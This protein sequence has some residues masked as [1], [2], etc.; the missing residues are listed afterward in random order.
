MLITGA[1]AQQITTI[2]GNGYAGSDSV[3]VAA[4]NAQLNKPT[5]LAYDSHF[6]LFVA[7]S[8]DG[9]IRKI[10]TAGVITTVCSGGATGLGD[11]GSAYFANLSSPYAVACDQHNNLY[12]ADYGNSRVRVIKASGIIT[13][14]AGGGT[15]GD[16][17]HATAAQ[18]SGPTGLAIDPIGNLYIADGNNN[19][20][21]KVDTFGIITTIAGTM[22]SAGYSGDGG[23]AT[24]AM[25]YN[26]MGLCF[27]TL[28]NLYIADCY[29]DC[30]RIVDTSGNINTFAG[31]IG[32]TTFSGDGGAATAA[33]INLPTDVKS[34]IF[35]N[36]YI[37]DQGNNAIRKVNDSGIIRTAAGRGS[38]GFTGDGG[39]ATN[40]KL[41]KPF[42]LIV[43][44][45]GNLLITDEYNERVRKVTSDTVKF[46]N[47]RHQ[48]VAMC[49]RDSV[50]SISSA[51]GVT[52]SN[53][54]FAIS[55]SVAGAPRHGRIFSSYSA[56]VSG[57][58]IAP[59]D[60]TYRSDS[61]YFGADSFKVLASDGF[62]NDS[63]LIV[64][65]RVN[66]LTAPTI[67]T[68]GYVCIGDTLSLTASVIGGLWFA[69]NNRL[70]DTSSIFIGNITG[71]DTIKYT[72]SN[73][74]GPVTSQKPITVI[75]TPAPP[76]IL[77]DSFVCV[78]HSITLSSTVSGGTWTKSNANVS[79]SAGIIHGLSAGYDTVYYTISNVCGLSVAPTNI[80]IDSP[81]TPGHISGD[82]VVCAGIPMILTETSGVGYW[83][84]TNLRAYIDPYGNFTGITGGLDTVVYTVGN[85][86]G[87]WSAQHAVRV[88]FY[89]AGTIIAPGNICIGDSVSVLDT[90]SSR[91]GVWNITN[92][93][94]TL[95]GTKITAMALGADTIE[96]S[97]TNE[98][99]LFTSQHTFNI[100]PFP[101]PG[102]ISGGD[103]LCVAATAAFTGIPTGGSWNAT[104][105]SL[106]VD[107]AGIA[108]GVYG[109]WDTLLYVLN[110]G[111][112]YTPCTKKVFVKPF[113]YA[114]TITGPGIICTG[115]VITLTDTTGRGTWR[116]AN[117]VTAMTVSGN[118][119]TLSPLHTGSN[120]IFYTIYNNCGP[121]T[122]SR[123]ITVS[124]PPE[125]AVLL[126]PAHICVGDTATFTV[127][128]GSGEWSAGSNLTA[129]P[130]RDSL[131]FSVTSL[132][133]GVDT[134]FYLIENYCG[135]FRAM[136]AF[137][138]ITT[139]QDVTVVGDS[140]LCVESHETLFGSP[141]GGTWSHTGGDI[142]VHGG[143]ITAFGTGTSTIFYSISNMCGT[144]IDTFNLHVVDTG[145]GCFPL[146]I[147]GQTN[148]AKDQE[149]SF[150]PNPAHDKIYI[151]FQGL[152]GKQYAYQIMETAS[153]E[154]IRSGFFTNTG[155]PSILNINDLSS[156]IYGLRIGDGT[157]QSYRLFI[158][159]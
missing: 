85:V 84:C 125:P 52:D 115:S 83:S 131:S 69:T 10:N 145:S 148:K 74:C 88:K 159:K 96:Y 97:F 17:S 13:T 122:V 101:A 7:S 35:G 103:T 123:V 79:L 59:V 134:L 1:A 29:N 32:S 15:G 157:Y 6:N 121:T 142:S 5:G 22:G 60:L 37:V 2:A 104:N 67:T 66:F 146:V 8:T 50:V 95:A 44:G 9:V 116:Q 87:S 113:P 99:G 132:L 51:L 143:W 92:T 120:I 90:T 63:T 33:S 23:A 117:D 105:P 150:F 70:F 57:G 106:A 86:C 138:F 43:V 55:W 25:L 112:C 14:F 154:I 18:L 47:G 158:K 34:D 111:Y 45:K 129:I 100:R 94:A 107:E 128:R 89:T 61:G 114:G 11:G 72:I 24:S 31:S 110:N 53:L 68:P 41:Y 119:V 91:S 139:P 151:D 65:T 77:G 42:G 126:G 109:G 133:T 102:S 153:S 56:I 147:A 12:I 130:L 75:A 26:P 144:T 136:S 76:T 71:L 48:S 54:R 30:I 137:N 98:C 152:P 38:P 62:S 82:T 149:W 73:L 40:A 78:A 36:I 20:V 58:L 108:S 21:R 19:C 141:T 27:D 155:E 124:N 156:G 28:G 64:I 4:T 39:A 140:V 135:T 16:G 127:T 93:H 46:A 3:N 49:I 118:S 81:L 80:E